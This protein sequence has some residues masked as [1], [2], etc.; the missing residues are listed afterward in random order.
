MYALK[1]LIPLAQA[2]ALVA[3]YPQP[4]GQDTS[5]ERRDTV[6]FVQACEMWRPAA[7]EIGL[8]TTTGIGVVWDGSNLGNTGLSKMAVIYDQACQ[9][10]AYG[11]YEPQS[12]G[13]NKRFGF[14]FD[15]VGPEPS[16]TVVISASVGF[17]GPDQIEG[18]TV[19]VNDD[20]KDLVCDEVRDEMDGVDAGWWLACNFQPGKWPGM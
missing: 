18:T 14:T 19:Y 15:G 2:A 12:P 6:D 13:F 11:E 8:L 3:G 7:N 4:A 1:T 20:K 16:Y 10:W 17:I 5:I 9:I